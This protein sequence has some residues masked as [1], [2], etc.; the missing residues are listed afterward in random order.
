MALDDRYGVTAAG[1]Y[2]GAT[3]YNVFHYLQTTSSGDAGNLLASF[4]G[5]VLTP[6]A[7]IMQESAQIEQI[8]VINLDNEADYASQILSTPEP[9]VRTGEGEPCWMTWT[10]R[11]TRVSR[12]NHHGRKAFPGVSETDHSGRFPTAGMLTVLE[13]LAAVLYA[14]IGDGAG[15]TYY[16]KIFRAANT[17]K[18]GYDNAMA[19]LPVA[20]VAF[21][22]ISTQKSRQA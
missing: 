1:S 2:D 19:L 17:I 10:Y 3:F 13:A 6:M 4:V 8:A 20:S 7:S 11:Y 5:N 22:K 14:P 15:S 21:S 16:P 18:P 12:G 9:G